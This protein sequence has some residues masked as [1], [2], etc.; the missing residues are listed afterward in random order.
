M[1]HLEQTSLLVVLWTYEYC[2]SHSFA[3]MRTNNLLS[4][5]LCLLLFLSETINVMRDHKVLT[6][7]SQAA[8]HALECRC[9]RKSARTN[10]KSAAVCSTC[11]SSLAGIAPGGRAPLA[12]YVCSFRARCTPEASPCNPA[13]CLTASKPVLKLHHGNLSATLACKAARLSSQSSDECCLRYA[14]HCVCLQTC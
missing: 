10:Q 5:G 7:D 13:I 3:L 1:S 9:P 14:Y 8:R 6:A 12:A 11:R 4:G 2:C